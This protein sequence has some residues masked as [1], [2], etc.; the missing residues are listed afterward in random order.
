MNIIRTPAS[1]EFLDIDCYYRCSI[2]IENEVNSKAKMTRMVFVWFS[3]VKMR[4]RPF[5]PEILSYIL[6]IKCWMGWVCAFPFFS[7][8]KRDFIEFIYIKA[9]S[10]HVSKNKNNR[11][12][13]NKDQSG[14]CMFASEISLVSGI[15]IVTPNQ[16]YTFR[17]CGASSA[18]DIY[19]L[20][21]QRNN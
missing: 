12:P 4:L 15:S 8:M 11:K 1:S 14:L 6:D 2:I 13:K 19:V 21:S 9:L 16:I 17:C 10:N 7:Y 20:A 3:L 18:Y 5:T